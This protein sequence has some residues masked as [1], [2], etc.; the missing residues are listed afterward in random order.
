MILADGR[1]EVELALD[2]IL[3]HQ[4]T[5]VLVTNLVLFK[6]AITSVALRIRANLSGELRLDSCEIHNFL[7]FFLGM[8]VS[9]YFPS[10]G[11]LSLIA[12]RED[13]R[14]EILSVKNP[15]LFLVDKNHYQ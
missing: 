15:H 1:I 9:S 8:A 10:H 3:L 13:A 5:V 2:L 14:S 7:L 4:L 6:E 11:A 12:C